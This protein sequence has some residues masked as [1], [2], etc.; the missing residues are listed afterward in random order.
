MKTSRQLEIEE[1]IRSRHPGM[2]TMADVGAELGVKNRST[3]RR[4]LEGLPSYEISG[5]RRWRISDVAKRLCELV[6]TT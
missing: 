5:R 6:G 3:I 4:F 1:D 2:L